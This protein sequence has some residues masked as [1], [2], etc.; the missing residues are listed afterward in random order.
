MTAK[1]TLADSVADIR[2]TI[3][4]IPV[5]EART[6]LEIRLSRTVADLARKITAAARRK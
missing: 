3:E 1:P 2:R 6:R 4:R 5:G